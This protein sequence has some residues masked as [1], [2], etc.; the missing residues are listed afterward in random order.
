MVSIGRKPDHL[1]L[2]GR[3]VEDLPE[4]NR[5]RAAVARLRLRPETC[6]DVRTGVL[7]DTT[8]GEF[9]FNRTH[10]DFRLERHRVLP[11]RG[12]PNAP[13]SDRSTAIS[14]R[15]GTGVAA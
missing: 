12:G 11:R 13:G 1:A 4:R 5:E 9:E 6:L 8:I 15:D 2:V 10:E 3:S 14:V 7:R